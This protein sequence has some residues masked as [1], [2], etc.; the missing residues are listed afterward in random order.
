[1]LAPLNSVQVNTLLY[2]LPEWTE[3][4][5][6]CDTLL[7]SFQHVIDLQV[8]SESSNAKA[9][10]RVR[11]LVTVAQRSQDV[12]GFQGRGCASAARGQSDILQCHQEGFAFDVCE[13][14]VDAARVECLW[15]AV[16]TGVLEGQQAP[17]E[18]VRESLDALG[19]ILEIESVKCR[20]L[21][22]LYGNKLHIPTSPPWQYGM[23]LQ[24][25]RP[26]AAPEFH[27]S[28]PSPDHLH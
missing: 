24:S 12:A 4:P 19:V 17:K 21:Q 2:Q 25:Q 5:Q 13:G 20:H 18:S 16:L 3:L 28:N 27:S 15:C 23:P 8:G 14:D 6:E 10:T 7:H 9:N 11:A 1:M 22:V 26:K